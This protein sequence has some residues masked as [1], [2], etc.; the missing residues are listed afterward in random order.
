LKFKNN[1]DAAEAMKPDTCTA[2]PDGIP[3]DINRGGDHREPRSDD[4]GLQYT[5]RPNYEDELQM[6]EI[7]T[8]T[9]APYDR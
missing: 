3:V 2:Y 8:S 4:N 6:W 9:G 1:F 5:L 7:G